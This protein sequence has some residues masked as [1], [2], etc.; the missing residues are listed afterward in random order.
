M[1]IAF[2]PFRRGTRAFLV[3]AA[4]IAA[5]VLNIRS[6][7][8]FLP[9]E[10]KMHAEQ[11]VLPNDPA[12]MMIGNI[13]I[14]FGIFIGVISL[15]GPRNPKKRLARSL[16]KRGDNLGAAEILVQADLPLQALALFK[17][18]R[19]W[20]QAAEIAK[21]LDQ[22]EEAAALYRRAGGQ[23]LAEAARI[24]RRSGKTELAQQCNH[25][26]ATWFID[27]DRLDSAIEAWVK[28]GELTRA[29]N[30]ATIAIKQQRINPLQSAFKTAI[31]AA[32]ETR[33]HSCVAQLRELES[34]W[35][36]AAKAWRLAANHTRAAI[37]F[38]KAGRLDEAAVE[39]AKAG[40]HRQAL[41]LRIEHLTRLEDKL[42]LA[43]AGGLTGAGEV[44]RITKIVD[45]EF[46]AI[47]P[48]LEELNMDAEIIDVLAITGRTEQAVARL[49]ESGD[50]AAAADFARDNQLFGIA[51]KILED[52]EKFAEASDTYELD[53][54]LER[55]AKCA[56]KAGLDQRALD[57]YRGLGNTT[58]VAHCMAR[59]GLLQ[60]A[61]KEMHGQ[62]NLEE[63]CSILHNHPGPIPDV[64][65]IVIEM[66]AWLKEN[67]SLERAIACLQRA[68]RGVAMQ[69]K[70]LD[71]AVALAE[72]LFEAGES[73]KAI[74]QL[75]RVL[76]FDYSNPKA[77]ELKK[78][79]ETV[80]RTSVPKTGDQRETTTGD[81]RYEILN[82]LGRGGMGVVYKARDNRLERIVA[83]KVLRTTSE[84]EAQRLEQEAKVA[85]TLNHPGIVTVYDFEA[86]FD[87][88][89]IAMEFIP[90]HS[91]GQILK[92]DPARFHNDLP[93]LLTRLADAVAYA[94][95][96]KVVHRDLK[97]GNILLTPDNKVMILDF[98]IATRIDKGQ[99]TKSAIVGTPFYM[100]PEQIL[101]ETP[102]PATDVYAFGATS[103]HLATGRPPFNKGNV[104]DAHLNTEP[105]NPLDLAPELSPDL[106]EIILRCLEK[107]PEDRYTDASELGKALARISL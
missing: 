7:I 27:N 30:T 36:D 90:G 21:D 22:E 65:E 106:S 34:N 62:N 39:K 55:A 63:A 48:R 4:I 40:D 44:R 5:F 19:A 17:K 96:R 91:F 47:L 25:E 35:L 101:G 100:A 93:S 13:L 73:K 71:P 28:A 74:T 84:Q 59:I 105:P 20:L 78:K 58:Q 68:V 64:P 14:G 89:F 103:F 2:I 56:E 92:D 104:I 29:V 98:G 12:V 85:A 57:L 76:G 10:L 23:N 46:E 87:G 3:T 69:P 60:D 38:Q 33:N 81:H 16:Q 1:C 70:R 37:N 86:G 49:E 41:L 50:A 95:S 75:D 43:R 18:S 52:L 79:I 102:T 99:S 54:D 67:Q 61:L 72:L 66:A 94:H 77:L 24:Y 6:L 107:E 51:G 80:A 97:P 26:L 11:L 88:Y 32:E 42:R 9:A 83:I 15:F 82:E 31:R 45:K 53:H 8:A